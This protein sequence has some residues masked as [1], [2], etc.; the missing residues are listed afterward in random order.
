MNGRPQ[1]N[2]AAEYYFRYIDRINS[3]DIL[4][5][6]DTQ[7]GEILRFLRGISE[8]RSLHRYA[9]GKW[10]VR[11]VLNHVNDC[12][13]VFAGR[14]FWF[15]R[16]FDTPLPSFD[17]NVSAAAADAHGI[18]WANHVED[19][20]VIRRSTLSLFRNLPA[21]AWMRSG[22]ASGYPFT[23]RALAYIAGGHVAHHRAMLE[24]RYL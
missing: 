18:P 14:A 15:A 23:V 19:F 21:D 9:T 13:R 8:E 22:T 10:S 12:E 11:Q 6:L 7:L 4:G 24:E 5:V 16:G 2:E 17:E 3:D 20:E 1:R